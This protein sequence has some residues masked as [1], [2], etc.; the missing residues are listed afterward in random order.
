MILTSTDY[1]TRIN[2]G[3]PF[4]FD[5]AQT[6]ASWFYSPGQPAL[7][8]LATCGKLVTG[9]ADEVKWEL[10]N[11]NKNDED[12]ANN[13]VDLESLLAYVREQGIDSVD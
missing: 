12:Y 8:T 13:K 3:L 4:N 11:L 10:D 1:A 2:H 9:I 6:I 5:M 7:V